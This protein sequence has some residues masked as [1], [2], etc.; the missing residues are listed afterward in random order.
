MCFLYIM[1]EDLLKA[2]LGDWPLLNAE[3]RSRSVVDGLLAGKDAGH[4]DITL[5]VVNDAVFV[6]GQ[7]GTGKS[8]WLQML[9]ACAALCHDVELWL[10]DMKEGAELYVWRGRVHRFCDNPDDAAVMIAELVK[11]RERRSRLLQKQGL[12]KWAPGCGFPFILL[13]IDEIAD[14]SKPDEPA[15]E[16]LTKLVRL[17]RAQGIGLILATQHPKADMINTTLRAQCNA[18]VAYR[19]RGASENGV[20]L[21]AGASELGLKSHRLPKYRFI[22]HG[23]DDGDGTTGRGWFIDDKPLVDFVARVLPSWPPPSGPKL[24]SDSNPTVH[25]LHIEPASSPESPQSDSLPPE[26]PAGIDPPPE[27]A[28]SAKARRLWEALPGERGEL[29][30]ASGYHPATASA[31]LS[32]WQD[33]GYTLNLGGR[34]EKRDRTD[35]DRAMA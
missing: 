5:D 17:G 32:E 6:S 31:K 7:R 13:V 1:T 24:E 33:A 23:H 16:M 9:V 19:T 35:I 27:T 28:K 11:E 15:Q 14:V 10:G 22:A 4:D 2:P 25:D 8:A 26:P 20:A 3:P 21:G 18:A 34:W 30:T 12:R 29:A